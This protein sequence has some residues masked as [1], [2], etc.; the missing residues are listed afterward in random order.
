MAKKKTGRPSSCTPILVEKLCGYLREGNSID[1]S[2]A[3]AGI[4]E[5]TYHNW[6]NWGEAGDEPYRSFLEAVKRARA[7]FRSEVLRLMRQAVA[8]KTM[9]WLPCAWLLE[10]TDRKNWGKSV[11]LE[12][13]TKVT[14]DDLIK[15]LEAEAN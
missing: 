4:A 7:E 13:E 12:A 15:Q 10:R 2:C 14:A 1:D 11:H 3:L 8:D 5:S 6:R 9:N